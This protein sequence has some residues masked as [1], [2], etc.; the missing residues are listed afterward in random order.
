MVLLEQNMVT[1]MERAHGLL[2]G[3]NDLEMP[4]PAY[5]WLWHDVLA[6]A[7]RKTRHINEGEVG[8]FVPE[9]G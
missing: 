8:V 1:G 9:C 6:Y 4:Y 3:D 5:R 2:L 7:W